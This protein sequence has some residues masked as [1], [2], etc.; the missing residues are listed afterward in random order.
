MK[1]KLYIFCVKLFVQHS[2]FNVLKN[3]ALKEL[4][5]IITDLFDLLI[6]GSVNLVMYV[7]I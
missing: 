2:E 1:T 6:P 4:S 3:G 7:R 5:V